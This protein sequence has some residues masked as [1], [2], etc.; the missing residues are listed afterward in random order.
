MAELELA[1]VVVSEEEEIE[2]QGEALGDESE[3]APEPGAEAEL[4]AGAEGGAEVDAGP[5]PGDLLDDDELVR[6]VA[7]L[8]FASPEPLPLRRLVQLLDGPRPGRVRTALTEIARRVD[9][10]GLPLELREIA[11]GWHFMTAPESFETV[12]KLSKTRKS[13][14]LSAAG[15]ETLA[16]VAY[17]QPVTK[18]EIEAIRG[19]QCG[20]MLRTLVDRGLV[21]VTG[22]ANQPGQPLQYGTT[23]SFLDRFGLA[24]LTDLPRDGELLGE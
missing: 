9:V 23:R 21:R 5:G 19:V 7:A 22:R 14:R 24:S 18:A 2:A 12:A 15:L 20:A 17:R 3:S 4:S 1:S 6:G 10:A 8:V 13:E 16:V 11:G